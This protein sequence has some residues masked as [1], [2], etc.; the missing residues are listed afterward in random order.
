MLAPALAV[1]CS[2]FGASAASG[3]DYH[4]NDITPAGATSGKLTA[5]SGGKQVGGWQGTSVGAPHAVLLTGNALSGVDLNPATAYYSMATC[6]DDTQQGGWAYLPVGIHA[7]V[8]SG[9]ASSYSDLNPSGYNF[10]YCLG[11]HNGEQ[12]GYAQQQS[13]FISASHAYSWHGSAT[14]GVDLHFGTYVFSRAVACRSGEEV[15]YLSSVAYPEGE[16]FGYHSSSHAARWAGTAASGVDLHPAGFD[17]S[18]ATCTSGTQQ[19]G[20]G[21]IA[22]GT[23]HMHALLWSGTPESV[24]DLH[25][26]GYTETRV[27]AM[28]AD[29]QVGDGWVGAP[30]AVGSIRHALAWSGTADTVV[31]LNQYLPAGYTHGVATGID[32]KGNIVGY[33][34]NTYQTGVTIP[35]NAIAVVFAPGAAPAA[36]LAS[37]SLSPSNVAPGATVQG[38]VSLTSPAPAGGVSISFLS[39]NATMATTPAAISIAEGEMSAGFTL[40]V[41]GNTLLAPASARIY[42]TDGNVS[43]YASFTV[44]PI[45]KLASVSGNTVEGGFATYGSVVLSIPAQAGGAAVT[46]TSGDPSVLSVPAT[47]TVPQGFQAY[48][49][50]LNTGAVSTARTVPITASFNGVSVTGSVTLSPAPV[51]SLASISVPD[52]VGGQS[53]TG[54]VALNNFSRNLAGT[55]VTLTSGDT[56]TLQVPAKVNIPYGAYS[57]TF[58]ATTSVVPGNKGVAIKAS[59]N[60]ANL[61]TTM[62]VFPVP[63]VTIVSADWDPV[64]LLFK[65][66]AN[67]SYANSILTFG[68]DAASG[69][70][71]TMQLELGVWKGSILMATAPTTAT[72][73][74]SNGGQASMPVTIK[75]VSSGGG[76]GTVK[77]GG[78]GGGSTTTTYKLSTITTGKG[79]IAIIPA[80]ASYA[81]GTVVTLTATPAAG[82]P[83]VGWSGGVVSKSQTISVTMNANISVTANFK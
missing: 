28:N 69:P 82:S 67:T 2:L 11:V 71:G 66:Q 19:G 47:I 38:A 49:F 72:V 74:N 51:I 65:V 6:M 50:S 41:G 40:P 3:Q 42:A 68:T 29:K 73:W 43:Q 36:Q 22:L 1:A 46:L 58:T 45:V 37:V 35:Q 24:V 60:G 54:T 70:I 39:T 76:G 10:S 23:S 34:F 78:G 21:Y 55:D 20:W 5:A 83:W 27:N 9:S 62:T 17:A 8:W 77:G 26:A 53:V 18:E 61:T 7:L 14:S 56:G 63:T 25:A 59:Y 16:Y 33:A 52:V 32:A 4:S 75:G 81:P 64:T 44:T 12:V 57:A 31:D 48:N 79:S 15:G 13:Y 80:A 30:G